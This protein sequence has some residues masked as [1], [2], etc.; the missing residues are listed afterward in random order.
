MA[1]VHLKKKE[2]SNR[3]SNATKHHLHIETGMQEIKTKDL[4]CT[5]DTYSISLPFENVKGNLAF[6]FVFSMHK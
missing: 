2:S 6:A 1:T 5:T 3:K 4:I